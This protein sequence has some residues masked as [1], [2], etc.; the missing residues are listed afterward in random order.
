MRKLSLLIL[1]ILLASPAW[2][3]TYHLAPASSGGSD[4]NSGTSTSSPWLT[5]NHNV[6]CGDILL[7]APGNYPTFAFDWGTVSGC[8]SG[9]SASVAWVQCATFDACKISSSS[10]HAVAINASN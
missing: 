8:G 2:A 4:S 3:T 5:P 6:N 9:S 7:A 1:L 10:Q